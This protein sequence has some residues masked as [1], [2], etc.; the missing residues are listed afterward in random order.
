MGAKGGASVTLPVWFAVHSAGRRR[1][2]AP[3]QGLCLGSQ[4]ASWGCRAALYRGL[5]PG[6]GDSG[7]L[8][9]FWRWPRWSWGAVM[10]Q[11]P[12]EGQ[13][14]LVHT[15]AIR[16]HAGPCGF[17]GYPLPPVPLQLQAA[18]WAWGGCRSQQPSPLL[19]RLGCPRQLSHSYASP[20]VLP[21]PGHCPC[22]G[23]SPREVCGP[24]NGAPMLSMTCASLPGPQEPS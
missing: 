19:L 18:C 15:V 2:L 14:P 10:R 16:E 21:V 4:R 22:L 23:P 12:R 3:L 8:T 9:M 20:I 13:M 7:T 6:A 24:R 1:G 11:G 17:L 5:G